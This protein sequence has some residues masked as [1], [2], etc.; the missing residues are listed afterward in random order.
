MCQIRSTR[1]KEQFKT[2]KMVR[3]TQIVEKYTLEVKGYEGTKKEKATIARPQN[4]GENPHGSLSQKS[5]D[6]QRVA[7]GKR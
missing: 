4:S 7:G 6:A 1:F 3:K 2:Q 5:Q